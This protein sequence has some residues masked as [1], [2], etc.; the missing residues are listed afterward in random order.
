M[1]HVQYL[2]THRCV[3][4]C[5]RKKF[6]CHGGLP[7]GIC[8]PRE[9]TVFL[10]LIKFQKRPKIRTNYTPFN[11]VEKNQCFRRVFCVTYLIDLEF[12][13]Y[14]IILNYIISYY[15]ILYYIVLYYIISYYIILYHIILYYIILYYIILYYIILYYIILYYIMLCYIILYTLCA[16]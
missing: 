15:I 16:S 12:A 10:T 9:I 7:P 5:H 13:H 1:K 6:S 4:G 11:L 3:T 8:P 2:R 14:Y